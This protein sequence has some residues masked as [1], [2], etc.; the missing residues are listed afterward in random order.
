M[1][2]LSYFKLL[3]P[4]QW[5]KN[6]LVFLTLF[7]TAQ[8]FNV[9]LLTLSL[10]GCVVLCLTSSSGYII[11][12]IKDLKEDRAHPE[13]R[14]RPIASGKV[15]IWLAVIISIILLILAFLISWIWLPKLFMIIPALL[16]VLT[17]IYSFFL[18]HEPVIDVLMIAIN[19]VIRALSGAFILNVMISPWLVMCTFFLALFL[20][21]GKRRADLMFLGEKAG[22][23]KK[24]F[25]HYTKEILDSAMYV[26]TSA[27]IISYSLYSFL[28]RQETL[29]IT[30]PFVFYG[31]FRY[32]ILI[33][34]GSD[35]ARHPEKVFKDWRMDVTM[36]LWAV[37][38]FILIY[39]Y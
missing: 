28:R 1:S 9:E 36:L 12:D 25:N 35:I 17:Q 37:L 31:I 15:P 20:V 4:Q 11:N 16:F 22:L 10:L 39:F 19:F 5:Y 29:L 34:S 30:L 6:V 8:V 7:F 38:T 14:L 21:F 2:V 27:L 26:S 33:Y 13:K 23:H 32:L 24:V 18:K 3:R